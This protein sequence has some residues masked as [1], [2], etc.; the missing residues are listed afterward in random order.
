V[1]KRREGERWEREREEGRRERGKEGKR[2]EGKRERGKG[3]LPHLVACRWSVCVSFAPYAA[4]STTSRSVDHMRYIACG[5]RQDP[6]ATPAF[7]SR[8]TCDSVNF[9]VMSTRAC[10]ASK[11]KGISKRKERGVENRKDER[12][13]SSIYIVT[14]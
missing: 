2:G 10:V 9:C 1:S 5:L 6:F 14:V 11:Q 7:P 8:H 13:F 12:I 4:S 3:R